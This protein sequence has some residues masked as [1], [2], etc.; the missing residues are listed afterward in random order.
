MRIAEAS[1]RTGISA[2]L[3]RYYEDQGLLDPARNSS[4][5]RDY[6]EDDLVAAR[7]VRQ[8]L[9]VGLSTA[10][11]GTVLPCLT[12]RLGQLTPVCAELIDELRHEQD[13]IISAIDALTESRDAIGQVIAA[14]TPAA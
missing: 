14:G 9:N 10:T 7:R 1:V 2:R 3:L 8:L 12:E 5:Y 11:I 6:S 4:G 13:R